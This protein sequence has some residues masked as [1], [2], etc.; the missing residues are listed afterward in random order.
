MGNKAAKAQQLSAAPLVVQSQHH[1]LLVADCK[2]KPSLWHELPP[3]LHSL[4]L[5]FVPP[6]VWGSSPLLSLTSLCRTLGRPRWC[7]TICA[8]SPT[9][10]SFGNRDALPFFPKAI[11]KM[12]ILQGSSLQQVSPLF[13]SLSLLSFSFFLFLSLSLFFPPP[14][15]LPFQA[16]SLSE[17]R[18]SMERV[19]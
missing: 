6:K 17:D 5:S 10:T 7:V 3:E 11:L 4:I 18:L 8:I 13:N 15:A 14:P 9:A 1:Q 16:L 2:G 19:L 12:M